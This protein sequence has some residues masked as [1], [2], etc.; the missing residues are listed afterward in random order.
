MGRAKV[1]PVAAVYVP[2]RRVMNFNACRKPPLGTF[3]S[4]S[5][6]INPG[7]GKRTEAYCFTASICLLRM[8]GSWATL[9]ASSHRVLGQRGRG[10]PLTKEFG[11]K[12]SRKPWLHSN[13]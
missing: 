4:I 3:K 11:T 8:T 5:N 10:H 13:V 12:E 9:V 2:P 6:P 7:T 1:K